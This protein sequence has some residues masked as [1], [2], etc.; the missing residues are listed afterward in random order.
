MIFGYVENIDPLSNF[1][2]NTLLAQALVGQRNQGHCMK[3]ILLFGKRTSTW[4]VLPT[5]TAVAGQ[6]TGSIFAET[7]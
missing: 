4:C 1:A 7:I 6:F 5:E 2:K 3:S